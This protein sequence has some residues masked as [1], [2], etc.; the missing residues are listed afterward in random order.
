MNI[1]KRIQRKISHLIKIYNFNY[2]TTIYFNFKMLPLQQAIHLPFVLYGKMEFW[3]LK[4]K[5]EISSPCHF[6]MI[7]WGGKRDGFSPLGIPSCLSLAPDAKL[8]IGNDV[9]IS[10]GCTL[11][12]IGTLVMENNSFLGSKSIVSCNNYIHIGCNTRIAF[13]SIITDT[14]FHYT[15]IDG[16]IYPKEGTVYIGKN[17]WIGNSS[18][19]T[20]GANIP[21]NSIVAA[22]SLVNKN[23][24]ENGEHLLL[25]GSPAKL[26]RTG[27]KRVFD[28]TLEAKVQDFFAKNPEASY[29]LLSDFEKEIL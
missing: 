2:L 28:T 20:K 1:L 13:N 12:I 11:R 14:N 21:N 6:G 9:W 17:C 25:A 5:I 29:Y 8:I 3:S 18:S 19:I 7:K 4:G 27:I 10:P 22:K 24:I 26:K 16:K 23:F 15:S